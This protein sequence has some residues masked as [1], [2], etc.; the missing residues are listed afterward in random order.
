LLQHVTYILE[1]TVRAKDYQQKSKNFEPYPE[2]IGVSFV[3][4]SSNQ[5]TDTFNYMNPSEIHS[6]AIQSIVGLET[7]IQKR[8][9]CLIGR[10]KPE[11]KHDHD[12]CQNYVPEYQ[13]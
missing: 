1:I 13:R 11:K 10:T 12:S 6:I 5:Q 2:L 4:M 7:P 9:I 3:D 8:D